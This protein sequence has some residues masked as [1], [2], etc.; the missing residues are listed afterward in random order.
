MLCLRSDG[1]MSYFADLTPHTYTP[2]GG[3]K[4]VNT[5][6]L[7]ISQPF[8]RGETSAEFCKALQALCEHPIILHRGFHECQFCPAE[9]GRVW[10]PSHPQRLGNGQIRVRSADGV[11][12]AAPVMVHHYVVEHRYR[13]PAVFIEAVLHPTAVAADAR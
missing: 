13:P 5:G 7:D 9:G 12:Y 4:V 3:E 1:G 6:W 8:E 2:T 11:W 10:P